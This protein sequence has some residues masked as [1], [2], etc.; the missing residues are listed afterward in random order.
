MILNTWKGKNTKN[1]GSL[2]PY[3]FFIQ[4][5]KQL[6]IKNDFTFLFRYQRDNNFC[7]IHFEGTYNKKIDIF[8][9]FKYRE[10]RI[11]CASSMKTIH[12][13]RNCGQR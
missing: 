2:S 3:L 7:S 4:K 8:A 10:Y 11:T 13:W 5:S 6:T 12:V 1:N 9:S